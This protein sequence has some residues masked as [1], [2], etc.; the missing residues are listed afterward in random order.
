[1]VDGTETCDCETHLTSEGVWVALV[2]VGIVFKDEDF[3]DLGVF[4]AIVV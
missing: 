4:D 2:G 3:V 1:M